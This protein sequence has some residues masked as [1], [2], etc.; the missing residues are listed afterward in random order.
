MENDFSSAEVGDAVWDSQKGSGIIK[1]INI[2]DA[3]YPIVVAIGSECVR[4]TIK[5]YNRKSDINPALFWD[6]VIII[7]PP[8]PKRKIEK[9]I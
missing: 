6:E 4:Y 9:T 8:K 3:G 5:G 1:E 7:P 2:N